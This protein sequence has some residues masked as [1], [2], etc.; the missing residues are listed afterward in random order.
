MGSK[1]AQAVQ[2]MII[3]DLDDDWGSL[4]NPPR[5][6]LKATSPKLERIHEVEHGDG[7]VVKR[8]VT[9]N[10]EV[11]SRIPQNHWIGWLHLIEK[12]RLFGICLAGDRH[13]RPD[14][15]PACAKAE[16]AIDR[17]TCA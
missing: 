16:A 14:I 6:S 17:K 7:P 3:H 12:S 2:N 8:V 5:S 11:G 9:I 10:S 15:E 1:N 4:D 13:S